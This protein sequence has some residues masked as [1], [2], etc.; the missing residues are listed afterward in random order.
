[1]SELM[2][3]RS[4]SRDFR[5]QLLTTVSALA[6]LTSVYGSNRSEAADQDADRPTV[7]IELGGQL[8]HMN[9]FAGG[10]FAAVHG[11]DYAGESFV[12][13]GCSAALGLRHR[14]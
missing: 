2:N 8:E 7:W 9:D 4:D 6:L 1:M 3:A 13:A 5:W 14:R 10:V 12:C 11:V